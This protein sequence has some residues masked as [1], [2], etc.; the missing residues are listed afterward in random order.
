[1]ELI[2]DISGKSV[3]E[4]NQL[5]KIKLVRIG[6]KLDIYSENWVIHNDT[7]QYSGGI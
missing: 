6:K 1:M 2:D 4:S 7:I 5:I 3:S